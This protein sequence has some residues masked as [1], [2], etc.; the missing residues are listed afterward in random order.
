M[1]EIE[2]LEATLRIMDGAL[3]ISMEMAAA[4][5][6]LIP[7]YD[8]LDEFTRAKWQPLIT[9]IFKAA[10]YAEKH[11]IAQWSNSAA[12]RKGTPE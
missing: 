3:A 1:S 5:K 2:K 10:E 12:I 11:Q 7:E 8:S 6:P 9:S 4:I